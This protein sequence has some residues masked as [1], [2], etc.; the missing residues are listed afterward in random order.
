LSFHQ[1]YR[2]DSNINVTATA[3]TQQALVCDEET[4]QRIMALRAE[5]LKPKQ[6]DAIEVAEQPDG[7]LAP[8]APR[9]IPEETQ[10]EQKE[11]ARIMKSEG[12]SEAETEP[13]SVI[14]PWG[15]NHPEV[16]GLGLGPQ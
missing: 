14:E 6:A 4:R 9:P 13:E 5:I 3:T 2:R 11:R 10:Q 15:A 12:L 7:L 8:I 1:D 16:E